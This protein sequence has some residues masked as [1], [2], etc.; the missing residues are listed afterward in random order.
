MSQFLNRPQPV[1][2]LQMV[3]TL[4]QMV[5]TGSN[6]REH[7]AWITSYHINRREYIKYHYVLHK[8]AMW[9][10][11]HLRGSIMERCPALG[12]IVYTI[13]KPD[14]VEWALVNH[15]SWVDCFAL[16]ELPN[17]LEL[18]LLACSQELYLEISSLRHHILDRSSNQRAYY[19]V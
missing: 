13:C 3:A 2:L 12:I 1:S 16:D 5:A 17:N 14:F 10:P 9:C 8:Y 19:D 11:L 15:C 18:A 6:Y 7:G 4:L